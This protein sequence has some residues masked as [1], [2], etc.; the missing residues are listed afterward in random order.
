MIEVLHLV[1]G[2]DPASRS[3]AVFRS[4]LRAARQELRAGSAR[5]LHTTDPDPERPVRPAAGADGVD[6]ASWSAPESRSPVPDG[7][8]PRRS[9]PRPSAGGT[10]A[11]APSRPGAAE[12]ATQRAGVRAAIDELRQHRGHR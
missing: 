7:A 11:V 6:G 3:P 4:G 2:A 8:V 10:S 12:L 1:P 5:R 9:L